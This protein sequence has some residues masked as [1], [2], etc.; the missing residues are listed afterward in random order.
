MDPRIDRMRGLLAI[1]VMLGHAILFAQESSLEPAGTLF[2]ITVPSRPYFGFI[3]VVGFIVLSGY[4]IGRSTVRNFSPSR[5]AFMRV[6]RLYPLLSVAALLTAA[7]E[8][9]AFGNPHRSIYWAKGIDVRTFLYAVGG[10]SGFWG[11]FGALAAAYTISFELMYYLIWGLAM[12]ASSRRPAR[13]LLLAMGV[14]TVLIALQPRLQDIV[15]SEGNHNFLPLAIAL[16]PAWLLGAALCV[17]E[18]AWTN[19]ARFIPIWATWIAL[20]WTFA[21]GFDQFQKPRV[22]QADYSD[23]AYFSIMSLL[24][25]LVLAAWLARPAPAQNATDKRLGEISYPLFLIHGP[26]IVGVQFAMNRMNFHQ[27]FDVSLAILV[28]ASVGVAATLT[29]LVERPLM[30]WRR[31]ARVFSPHPRIAATAEPA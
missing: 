31:R 25:V 15:T 16:I 23:V 8:W 12:T 28:S 22:M 14:A 27:S 3:C 11:Q 29:V 30:A 17:F 19:V 13:A 4:C 26:V 1:G 24:F 9:W 7:V 21:R 20:L 5:Y 2:A 6:T 10:L 18:R